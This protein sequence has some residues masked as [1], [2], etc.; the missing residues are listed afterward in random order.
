MCTI[1][2]SSRNTEWYV[3]SSHNTEWYVELWMLCE[4]SV[5]ICGLCVAIFGR[6]EQLVLDLFPDAGIQVKGPQVSAMMAIATVLD[7]TL[8]SCTRKL[9]RRTERTS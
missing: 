4:R 9:V 8:S 1:I 3:T 6:R 7:M 2:T 5:V